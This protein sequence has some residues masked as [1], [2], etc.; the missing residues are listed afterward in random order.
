MLMFVHLVKHVE[1]GNEVDM[2]SHYVAMTKLFSPRQ[3]KFV[4]VAFLPTSQFR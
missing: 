2:S 4:N 1:I 3:K